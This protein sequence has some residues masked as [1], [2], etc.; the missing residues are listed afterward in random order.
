MKNIRQNRNSKIDVSEVNLLATDPAGLVALCERG[1]YEQLEE[2]TERVAHAGGR[3][4]VV[5]LAGPSSSGKTTTAYKLS[6][7]FARRG[8]CAPVISLDDFFLGIEHYPRLPD[9]QPDM[10]AVE[11]LDLPLINETLFSLVNRGEAWFPT[12]DFQNSCRA[13]Q[14]RLIQLGANGV[15]IIEGLH[16]LNP[17]LVESLDPNTLFRAYVSTRTKY[18]DG[19]REVLTPKDARL[20]RR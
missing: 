1:Y 15:L 3:Y 8:L 4:R 18:M 9:G 13:E 10:E 12:F 2:L 20:I 16:A 17:R 6:E 11:C 7:S 19:D 14:R 5:L